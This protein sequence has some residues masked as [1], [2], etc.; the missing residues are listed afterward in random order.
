[1]HESGNLSADKV[2]HL[3]GL[4]KIEAPGVKDAKWSHG[5]SEIRPLVN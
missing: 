1:M 3:Q 5:T 4:A 2:N